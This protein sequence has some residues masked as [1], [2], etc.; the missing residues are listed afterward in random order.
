M[1]LV[2]RLLPWAA[3]LAGAALIA[4]GTWVVALRFQSP[5]QREAPASLI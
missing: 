5:A 3:L 1:N 2:R 4:A